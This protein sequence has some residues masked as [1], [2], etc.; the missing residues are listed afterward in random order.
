M[1]GWASYHTAQAVHAGRRSN[2]AST[3]LVLYRVR[4]SLDELSTVSMLAE[5]FAPAIHGTLPVYREQNPS[6]HSINRILFPSIPVVAV[7]SL[8]KLPL[9]FVR[10]RRSL[11]LM[12]GGTGARKRSPSA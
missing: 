12:P 2:L 7:R 10:G 1:G 5:C 4:H 9:Y 8:W 3:V 6:N 11:Y